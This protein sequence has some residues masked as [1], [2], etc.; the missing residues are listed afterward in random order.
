MRRLS[1]G[2]GGALH[3]GYGTLYLGDTDSSVHPSANNYIAGDEILADFGWSWFNKVQDASHEAI[4]RELLEYRLGKRSGPNQVRG[5]QRCSR[6]CRSVATCFDQA[7]CGVHL[8]L[9]TQ[10]L[11]PARPEQCLNRRKDPA[12]QCR[13]RVGEIC[14][15]CQSDE[16]RQ[17]GSEQSPWGERVVHCDGC[18]RPCHL[19]CIF[20][21]HGVAGFDSARNN[22]AC[23]EGGATFKAAAGASRPSSPS[24]LSCETREPPAEPPEARSDDTQSEEGED[25]SAANQEGDSQSLR[26]AME[27]PSAAPCLDPRG[28]TQ[29][30]ERDTE[31]RG[32]S[33]EEAE[34]TESFEDDENYRWFTDFDYKW[35]CC[36][37]RLQWERMARAMNFTVD[38]DSMQV[39]REGNPLIP[40]SA[41]QREARESELRRAP[42]PKEGGRGLEG[43][44][45]PRYSASVVVLESSGDERPLQKKRRGRRANSKGSQK[46]QTPS[47]ERRLRRRTLPT[48][49]AALSGDEVLQGENPVSTDVP[50]KTE[51]PSSKVTVNLAAK[52]HAL[53]DAGESQD[54]TSDE[55]RGVGD[56]TDEGAST[57]V[58]PSPSSP[59]KS[60]D[61]PQQ[62]SSSEC[63]HAGGLRNRETSGPVVVEKVR[64]YATPSEKEVVTNMQ[65]S[66]AAIIPQEMTKEELL[67]CKTNVINE[68]RGLLGSLQPCL[69]CYRL[70]GARASVEVCR[71]TKRHLQPNWDHP[72]FITPAQIQDALLTCFQDGLLAVQSEYRAK[73]KEWYAGMPAHMREQRVQQLL[74]GDRQ[75]R[76]LED[77]GSRNSQDA[78]VGIAD[79][80]ITKGYVPIFGVRVGKTEIRTR[81]KAG[82]FTG[83]VT[84]YSP[85]PIEDGTVYTNQFKVDYEDGDSETL[86]PEGF[87]ARLM[88]GEIIVLT[89]VSQLLDPMMVQGK[90]LSS[91]KFKSLKKS[92]K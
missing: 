31:D 43:K 33:A 82:W 62:T 23:L 18:D 57:T 42:S 38:W 39:L 48:A 27:A 92:L 86:T 4:S 78:R 88:K 70:L 76:I 55:K 54:G 89:P 29:S 5:I 44:P 60:G 87:H 16:H 22:K 47:V 40:P 81:F 79:R 36:V 21:A 56:C 25:A 19:R 41:E 65:P 14:P 66:P 20:G 64:V 69:K 72:H 8:L 84:E 30:E 68:R 77:A 26:A 17:R 50:P 59:L 12:L 71:L 58:L 83:R 6:P 90:R 15:Y 10:R 74:R 11:A 67:G 53:Q 2:E 73:L 91:M 34:E 52:E 28:S 63:C 37:C 32:R 35:Y 9:W 7:E 13:A 1:A 51:T 46:M 24:D 85:A 3:D 49:S 61:D 45:L 80:R 75:E